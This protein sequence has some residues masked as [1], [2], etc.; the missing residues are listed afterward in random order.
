MGETLPL[1]TASFNRAV[2]VESR[3]EHLTGEAGG[4]IQRELMDRLGIIDWLSE[5][6]DD[7]RD[8]RR[9][10]YPLPDLIRT[11]L[12]L[13][14]QGWRDQDD[15]D[16]LRDDPSLRV[17]RSSCRGQTPLAEGQVLA[18][19][20]T[21]SRLIDNLSSDPNR[22]VLRAA[23]TETAVRRIRMT[24]KGRKR[25][26]LTLDVD[27]LP[28]EVHGH[29][30]GSEWNKYYGRRIYHPLVASCAETGDLLD[31]VLRPGNVGTAAGGLDFILEQVDR[32]RNQLAQRVMVRFDAGFPDGKTLTGLEARGVDY[33]A[34]I[35][36]NA[37]LDAMAEP[38]L[39]RP[40]GR[41]PDK[42]R[43]WCHE[44]RYQAQSW[45]RARR[46]VLV[47][48]EQ[49]DDLFLHH[50]WLIT[51]LA[52]GR[53]EGQQLLAQYRQR[54]KAEAHMGELMDV[55]NPALSASPRPWHEADIFEPALTEAGVY[56]NNETLFLLHLLAYEV[57]HAGRV[58]MERATGQGW[59]LRRFRE[60]LL[61]VAARV[62][63]K[64]RRLTFVIAWSAAGDWSRFWRKLQRYRW[65][66]A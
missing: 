26:T 35:R 66:P 25:K 51:N 3:P 19:Q 50:F 7:C 11:H 41:P 10:T 34:R 14:G 62:V 24:N 21:L 44:Y 48:L 65:S 64:S 32:C 15:A 63:T 47:V 52:P 45:D 61:R 33:M 60:R 29:Q 43:V 12:L 6:L 13:L 27:S 58:I 39:K 18:S 54:G 49:P 40:P 57:L 2:Q 9:V 8:A 17:A 38:H 31:A 28:V 1:F 56:R 5:H 4:L 42:P 55:L 53:C 16:R 22:A 23:I 20:P 36:N 37:V 59:S 46:V 30:A